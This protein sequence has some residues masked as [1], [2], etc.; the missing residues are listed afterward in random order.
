MNGTC[1]N[2]ILT[3]LLSDDERRVITSIVDHIESGKTKVGIKKIASEN[4]VS[5]AFVMKLSKRLGFAGYSELYYMLANGEARQDTMSNPLQ[6]LV[7]NCTEEMADHF[8]D[9][10]KKHQNHKIF[11]VGAG[12]AEY[13]TS[14]MVQRLAV[15]G[16]MVFNHVHFYDYMI[17]R[18]SSARQNTTNIEPSLI[19]AISQ[20]GESEA[21][22]NDVREA[23]KQDF[24]V[25]SFTRRA[26]S[27]LAQLSDLAF[28]VDASRQTLI[29]AVPN[30]FFGKV[31]LA[32]EE[33]MGA[34]FREKPN[35]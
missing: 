30:P 16:F 18:Q 34:F 5:T 7:D 28:L 24:A 33:L 17:F 8:C 1:Y 12:F 23:K 9:L 21:V 2:Y 6:Q 14:Y 27:T 22:I 31:L 13:V 10:L 32:F 19:I 25:V 15:C 11:V 4:Y 29:S 20:S 3:N 35:T 26:D